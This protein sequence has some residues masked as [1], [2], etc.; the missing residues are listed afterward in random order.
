[1]SRLLIFIITGLF[2][3]LMPAMAIS[4]SHDHATHEKAADSHRQE[5]SAPDS[6]S[7]EGGMF[8]VGDM[9]SKGVRG[10]A[11]LKDVRKAMG[12]LGQKTTHHF[13]IAFVDVETGQQIESGQVALKIQDPDGNVSEPIELISMQGHFGADIVLDKTGDYHL[14]LGTQLRDEIKRTYHFHHKVE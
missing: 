11:H 12:K 14:K 1:M 9:T 2:I 3:L 13:M 10:M 7:V 5:R 6:M 8:I 4:M